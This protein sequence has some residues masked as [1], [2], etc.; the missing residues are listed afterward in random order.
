MEFFNGIKNF[1]TKVRAKDKKNPF[2]IEKSFVKGN[3]SVSSHSLAYMWIRRLGFLIMGIFLITESI[4]FFGKMLYYKNYRVDNQKNLMV[5]EVKA[6]QDKIN[7]EKIN[8][9]ATVKDILQKR[10][11]MGYNMAQKIYNQSLGILD[12]PQ[13]E[14]L[15]IESLRGINLRT[16]QFKVITMNGISLLY[17]QKTKIQKEGVSFL[18]LQ[19]TRGTYYIKDMLK[20]V[21][22]KK[23]GMFYR[24]YK[25][26]GVSIEK[27]VYYK[28][29]EPL[30][31]VIM[32]ELDTY[33]Y[34][35][36]FNKSSDI[37]IISDISVARDKYFK[38]LTIFHNLV[39]LRKW[40]FKFLRDL[41]SPR[42]KTNEH[43]LEYDSYE[44]IDK[45]Q[46]MEKYGWAYPYVFWDT[47]NV[48]QNILYA[49]WDKKHNIIIFANKEVST[50]GDINIQIVTVFFLEMLFRIFLMLLL[51]HLAARAVSKILFED[52]SKD[53]AKLQ[54]DLAGSQKKA[55][56]NQALLDFMIQSYPEALLVID[57]KTKAYRGNKAFEK[58]GLVQQTDPL[59]K[60]GQVIPTK[61]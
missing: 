5:K 10:A 34:T 21:K 4:G 48:K 12:K 3:P 2:V 41:K 14:D 28:Y 55:A 33:K 19:D 29:Y 61:K 31:F 49:K 44:K 36:K 52:V 43:I 1:V 25:D 18:N 7:K 46:E 27:A 11:D 56:A 57:E 37:Q 54:K 22:K 45:E 26:K 38:D 24:Y 47:T 20:V 23:E 30:E 59:T 8:L 6:I 17:S 39:K 58:K 60:D 32:T 40:Q 15:V 35:Q 42:N 53:V 9:N 50:A 51:I 13:I 16:Q